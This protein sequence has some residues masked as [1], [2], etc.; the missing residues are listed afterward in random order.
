MSISPRVS[1]F[2]VPLAFVLAACGSLGVSD[3]APDPSISDR[4]GA[5]VVIFPRDASMYAAVPCSLLSSADL[6]RMGLA[7]E[8][9]QRTSVDV[10][11]C[12]WTS[13]TRERLAMYVDPRRDLLADTYRT[14][15]GAYLSPTTIAGMPAVKQKS[16]SAAI[17]ICTVTTGL[18]S[19]Q[20]L[21][22]TWV[23]SGEPSLLN[24]ACAYAE[25]A[26]AMVIPKLPLL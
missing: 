14:E 11:E 21:E 18:A 15:R 7:S 19:T 20:A 6:S 26:A 24:D 22:T 25:Q 3:P 9:R 12:S 2:L 1:V 8:G 16:R 23:G 13:A 10:Q 17:N 4:S 5:P